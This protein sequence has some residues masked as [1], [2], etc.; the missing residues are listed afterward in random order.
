MS[1]PKPPPALPRQPL[2]RRAWMR[3]AGAL[4]AWATLAPS[5]P[6]D[7]LAQKRPVAEYQIKAAF[8]YK[9]LGYV[10]WPPQTF[11]RA[12]SPLVVG[13]VGASELASE[14]ATLSQGRTVGERSV[15]VR[16]LA[17]A[18]STAGLHA[19]FIGR[20]AGAQ[21]GE[22]AAR[23]RGTPVLTVTE[24]DEAFT[25]GAAINLVVVGDRVRF[26]VAPRNAENAQLKVSSRLL[27][28]ARKVVPANP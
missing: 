11:A 21:R 10:E 24:S 18:D 4:A 12:D 19:L 28:V 14:L 5:W 9:F 15:V 13:V 20:G 7:A 3:G 8:L 26:D 27:A 17:A 16:E 2:S 1:A 25:L 22:V 6:R 23:A